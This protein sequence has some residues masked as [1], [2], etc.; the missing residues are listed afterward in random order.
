MLSVK[1]LQDNL[2]TYKKSIFKI[3]LVFQYNKRDL[4]GDGIPLL[5]YETM[6]KDL[7]SRLKVPSFE[8]SALQG[9][10]VVKT[11]KKII[12]LTMAALEKEFK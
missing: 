8:A 9:D 1:N 11:L 4:A 5:S 10:N 6:E 7:N 2:A 3:P 12:T